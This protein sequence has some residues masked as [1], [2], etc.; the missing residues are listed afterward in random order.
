M[1]LRPPEWINLAAMAV[2][3]ALALVRTMDPKA[4][5]SV[6]ALAA[7]GA[8]AT[9]C[10]LRAHE[11]WGRPTGD[12]LRDWLPVVLI[13][14]PYWQAGQFD[15]HPSAAL[16]KRF[17]DWDHR[18]L[19]VLLAAV[20]QR[21]WV[22]RY[23]E[24]AYLLFYTLNPLALAVLYWTRNTWYVDKFWLWVLPPTYL[25]YVLLP[26]VQTRPPRALGNESP[27]QAARSVNLWLLDSLSIQVNTFPSCH[28]VASLA[29]AAAMLEVV[30]LAGVLFLWAAF[31]V[32]AGAVLGRY[33]YLADAAAAA[34]LVAAHGAVLAAWR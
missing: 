16:E 4:R 29:A 15:R 28:V 27:P 22:G 2:F 33:H 11:W 31:S 24:T 18:R 13:L 21:P 14:V 9:V 30:P 8:A 25:C 7:L 3:A 19:S 20:R 32:A 5:A 12:A 6:L 34:L 1:D 23:L 10:G 17:L 26:F